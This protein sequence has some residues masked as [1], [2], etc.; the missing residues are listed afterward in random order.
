MH[1]LRVAASHV[2]GVAV[3]QVKAKEVLV[4]L[5][6]EHVKAHAEVLGGEALLGNLAP[7]AQVLEV[8]RE[9]LEVLRGVALAHVRDKR[10]ALEGALLGAG[11][12]QQAVIAQLA[13]LYQAVHGLGEDVERAQVRGGHL[14]LL[15]QVLA[16]AVLLLGLP[17]RQAPKTAEASARGGR[18]S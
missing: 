6:E 12:G 17:G 4:N 14:E 10:R 11:H 3:A 9:P 1:L 7:P 8:A 5:V 15:E 18:Q 13:A 16:A 2:H